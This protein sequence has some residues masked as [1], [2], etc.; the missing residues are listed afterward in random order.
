MRPW[1]DLCMYLILFYVI[2]FERATDL[3]TVYSVRK[4]TT[5][6]YGCVHGAVGFRYIYN[7]MFSS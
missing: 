7:A 5:R 2:Q 4:E 1:D 6:F 3:R